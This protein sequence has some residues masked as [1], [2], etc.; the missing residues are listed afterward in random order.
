MTRADAALEPALLAGYS[1]TI[2]VIL[3]A[4]LALCVVAGVAAS[5]RAVLSFWSASLVVSFATAGWIAWG[6]GN[7]EGT[8]YGAFLGGGAFV[9]G[10]ASGRPWPLHL[11]ITIVLLVASATAVVLARGVPALA[12]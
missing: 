10:L 2:W 1:V 12:G 4:T 6:V 9:A 11:R 5:R 7:V 3:P 8:L